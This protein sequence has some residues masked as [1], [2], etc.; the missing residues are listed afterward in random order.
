MK[1]DVEG[2]E[3]VALR[4]AA[5]SLEAHRFQAIYFEYFE[6]NLARVQSSVAL[7]AFLDGAGYEVCFCRMADLAPLGRPT[8]T[9][10]ASLPGH[11]LRLV[12]VAGH[13]VPPMTDLLA[14][15]RENMARLP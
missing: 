12:P 4:G 2:H 11:G 10:R 7:L 3:L 14:I 1:M 6:K 8:H 9:V 5:R 15:P 13:A